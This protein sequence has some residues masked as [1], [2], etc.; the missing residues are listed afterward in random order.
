MK[1]WMTPNR[2]INFKKHCMQ[3]GNLSGRRLEE[4]GE[5]EAEIERFKK[6]FSY[7]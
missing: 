6:A 3:S 7:G 4:L 5:F 2:I 1:G